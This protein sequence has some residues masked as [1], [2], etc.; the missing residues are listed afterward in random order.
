MCDKLPA[1]LIISIISALKSVTNYLLVNLSIADLLITW[2]CVPLQATKCCWWWW[3][4]WWWRFWWRWSSTHLFR[5]FFRA[6]KFFSFQMTVLSLRW[7]PFGKALCHFVRFLR[8]LW[9]RV[10]QTMTTMKIS[11]FPALSSLQRSVQA[12]LHLSQSA[13]KGENVLLLSLSLY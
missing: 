8:H 5:G 9:T 12:P 1:Y 13:P 3:F 11:I 2:L 6:L 7:F 4:Q 10:V